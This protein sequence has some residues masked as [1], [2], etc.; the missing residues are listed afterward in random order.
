MGTRNI[1]RVICDGEIKVNQ[2]CQWDG[3]PTGRGAEV[4]KFMH[5]ILSDGRIYTFEKAIKKS[6]LF[7]QSEDSEIDTFYT[8]VPVYEHIHD[9]I[10][11]EYKKHFN[12]FKTIQSAVEKNIITR[13]E[14][15]Y[16]MLSCRDTG[17]MILEYMLDYCPC[18][19]VFYT[20]SYTYEISEALD[21]Q[22]EGMFIIDLDN[23]TVKICYHDSVKEYSFDTIKKMD[24]ELIDSDMEMF[25]ESEQDEVF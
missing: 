1:T 22:I 12:Y 18:G 25:E 7:V 8:G 16:L 19:M 5:S 4:L 10:S 20:N 9:L 23:E 17:N 6:K 2:Y 15:T 11:E 21:W 14:A 13:N 3:Y 24:D